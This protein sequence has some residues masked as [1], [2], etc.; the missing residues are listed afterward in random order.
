MKIEVIGPGCPFCNRLY[1]RVCEVLEE[2]RIE[3]EILHVKDLR[4]ALKYF[5]RTPVLLAD[6]RI[7][8][9]GKRL[10]PKERILELLEAARGGSTAV[11]GGVERG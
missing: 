10:P 11:G 8:H 6:G 9:R 4:T 3:A 1:K 7:L 5:P 2:R